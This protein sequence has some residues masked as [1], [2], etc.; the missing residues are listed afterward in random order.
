MKDKLGKRNYFN[1]SCR[2]RCEMCGRRAGRLYAWSTKRLCKMCY[3]AHCRG[4]VR[5]DN[6]L[7]KLRRTS[8]PRNLRRVPPQTRSFWQMLFG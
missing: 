4:Y 3:S 7:K 8:Q 2:R 5:V 6:L 1:N